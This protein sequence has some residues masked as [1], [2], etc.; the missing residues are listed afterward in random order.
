MSNWGKKHGVAN[1]NITHEVIRD[2]N[3]KIVKFVYDMYLMFMFDKFQ[4]WFSQVF[5]NCNNFGFEK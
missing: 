3:G 1:R 5:K 2:K 4:S